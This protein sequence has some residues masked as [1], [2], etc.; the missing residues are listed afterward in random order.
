[1][2]FPGPS[3][4]S[5]AVFR[6]TWLF[7]RIWARTLLYQSHL[8]KCSEMKFRLDS[9]KEDRSIRG[10][11]PLKSRELLS[12]DC[13]ELREAIIL[14]FLLLESSRFKF[15]DFLLFL[16]FWKERA[17]EPGRFPLS[18]AF[19]HYIVGD[20][21]CTFRCAILALSSAIERRAQ[22]LHFPL[23]RSSNGCR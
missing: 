7:P 23:L 3:G 12:N 14:Y 9:L 20:G 21:W 15:V 11:P 5:K 2:R 19:F 10:D 18:Q 13:S 1:M 16:V 8:V 6:P 22:A 17:W 4:H